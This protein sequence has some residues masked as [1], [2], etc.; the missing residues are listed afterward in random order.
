LTVSTDVPSAF[1]YSSGVASGRRI[2]VGRRAGSDRVRLD[3]A[4]VVLR[5]ALEH[6][7]DRRPRDRR[8]AGRDEPLP[9]PADRRELPL[10]ILEPARAADRDVARRIGRVIEPCP[11]DVDPVRRDVVGPADDRAHALS[12][13]VRPGGRGPVVAADEAATSG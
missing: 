1:A 13:L 3:D 2:G 4:R 12:R 11:R 10:E 5:R 9:I 8:R 6:R 7:L